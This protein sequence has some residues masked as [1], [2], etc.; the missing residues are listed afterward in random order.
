[1]PAP[2]MEQ[3]E[4]A[5]LMDVVTRFASLWESTSRFSLLVKFEGQPAWQAMANLSSRNII[6]KSDVNKP[7]DEEEESLWTPRV[8]IN[9]LG[10]CSFQVRR[11]LPAEV[12]EVSLRW[13]GS[14][15][16][17]QAQ[18]QQKEIPA[19]ANQIRGGRRSYRSP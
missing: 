19:H 14:D 3:L 17:R 5:I 16:A 6:R 9:G 4:T 11:R 10:N 1:M 13:T 12:I 2:P 15:Y 7:T 18:H 8:P